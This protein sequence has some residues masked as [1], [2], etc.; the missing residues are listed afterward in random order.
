MVETIINLALFPAETTTF[1]E[2]ILEEA[3]QTASMAVYMLI[4]AGMKQQAISMIR[5][6]RDNVLYYAKQVNQQVGQWAPYSKD[7][8]RIYFDAADWQLHY[9]EAVAST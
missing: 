1:I 7:T 6:T 5:W 8:F 3:L 9:L 4:R 2:F